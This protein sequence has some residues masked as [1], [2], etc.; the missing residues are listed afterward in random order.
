M[1]DHLIMEYIFPLLQHISNK[2]LFLFQSEFKPSILVKMQRMQDEWRY[3][4]KQNNFESIEEIFKA[5]PFDIKHK[6]NFIDDDKQ[7]RRRMYSST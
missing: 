6:S 3:L 2:F 4:S 1:L 5:S 7:Q